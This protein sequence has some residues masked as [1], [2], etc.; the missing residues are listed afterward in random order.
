VHRDADGAGLIGDGAGDGL[1]DPPRGVRAELVAALVLELLDRLHQADVALLDEVEE[2]EPAVRVLLRDRHDEPEV[3]LD[4]LGLGTIGLPLA[5]ADGAVGPA[6]LVDVELQLLFEL[7]QALLRGLERLVG[8][9]ELAAIEPQLLRQRPLLARVALGVA[10]GPLDV[11]FRDADPLLEL[12]RLRLGPLDALDELLEHADDLVDRLLVQPH[13]AEQ[14]HH[15]A[16]GR[17]DLL[18]DLLPAGTTGLL[19]LV[20]QLLDLLVPRLDLVDQA[21]DPAVGLF[22]VEVLALVGLLRVAD[23]VLDADLVLL[24]LLAD[25]DDLS[26]R[27]GRREDGREHPLLALL[28]ALRDLDLALAGE[29]RDRAHLPQVHPDGVVGLGVRA[30]GVL[31]VLA[32]LDRDPLVLGRL[33]LGDALGSDLHLGG[34]VDDLDVLVAQRAH[35]VIEL[36]SR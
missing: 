19:Q 35:D 24:E 8:V 27:D 10:D 34:G 29:E 22:L 1:A 33:F 18:G 36:I 30:V 5:L 9:G 28:D 3:R 15:L 25:L 16:V 20:A 2:L 26:D 4:Q 13:L 11:L 31:D 17:L 6:D 23:D 14:R 7:L 21:D 32:A 12:G